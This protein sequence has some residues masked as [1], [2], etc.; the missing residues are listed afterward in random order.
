[1]AQTFVFHQLLLALA[2]WSLLATCLLSA[3]VVNT[4][5]TPGPP[6]HVSCSCLVP[7][8]PQT[9]SSRSIRTNKNRYL[10]VQTCFSHLW[11]SVWLDGSLPVMDYLLD[12]LNQQL[13]D[14]TDLEP[15]CRRVRMTGHLPVCPLCLTVCLPFCL[16]SLLAVLHQD[17]VLQYV[18]R[19]MKTGQ[20]SREQQ[21]G[22]AQR[23]N[24]DEQKIADFFITEVRLW[25]LCSGLKNRK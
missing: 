18:K 1:M 13:V 23:M 2:T 17:V 25:Q 15:T 22:G 16:Q 20:K 6:G 7:P 14:L 21:V 12:S 24:E 9:V 10:C 11:T 5:G 3:A 4:D 8:L 19:M